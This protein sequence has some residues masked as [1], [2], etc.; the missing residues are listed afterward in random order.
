M[1]FWTARRKVH[2]VIIAVLTVGTAITQT[3]AASVSSNALI[4]NRGV[5]ELETGRANDISVRMAEEIASIV[6]DGSTRRVIPI[7][8]KGP[9]QSLTD[10]RYLRGIDLAIVPVD[11]L[12]YARERR[13]VPGLEALTYVLKLYNEEFHLLVGREVKQI[14]D[15]AEKTV[16]VDV[17]GSS[18]ALTATRLFSMLN[19]N[20]NLAT[21]STP[22]ALQK[23]RNGQI[24]AVAYVAAK[25]AMPFQELKSGDGLHLLSIP[26]PKAVIDTYP[27]T[28]ITA[29]DYPSLVA[30]D[31]TINTIDVG[32]VLM[33][34]DLRMVPDRYRNVANFIDVLFTGFEGLLAPGHDP[35]WGEIN[36]GAEVPG[37]SRHPAAVQWLQRN[38]QVA[39]PQNTDDLKALFARFVDERRQA[40][41]TA[42]LTDADKDT[43]FEQFRAWQRG[44]AH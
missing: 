15:L 29:N 44:Q 17:Q 7:V 22:I 40:S 30:P 41:G 31:Q 42:P 6:D 16:N 20:V 8:G 28:R 32:N 3:S 24:A 25:P 27:P 2:L 5:V 4:A 33:A 10:L 36:I 43:L 18:T 11:A 12:E 19:L 38:I 1:L 14:T 13:Y 26:L 21:D 35:K 9:L 39:A 34:A 37:W 23:L